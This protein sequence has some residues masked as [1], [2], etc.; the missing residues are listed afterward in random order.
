MTELGSLRREGDRV[1]VRF[2]RLLD[3]AAADVWR[4]LTDPERLSR[5]LAAVSQIDAT[6]GGS[7]AFRFGEGETERADGNVLEAEPE[8]LLVLEWRFPGEP[9]SLVRFELE[10]SGTGTRLVLDHSR[11]AEHDAPA[12]GAG[13]HA[14]IDLLAASLADEDLDWA[15]RYTAL[16]P[17]YDRSASA[18]V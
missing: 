9:T 1:G 2:E 11:L 15:V 8:R 13:W 5:W 3:A 10:A 18:L 14:H 16:R 7:F 12:Y 4:E 17:D 6:P